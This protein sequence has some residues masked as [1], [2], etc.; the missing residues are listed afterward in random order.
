MTG[1]VKEEV[2]TRLIELGV[3]VSAGCIYFNPFILRQSEFLN[4]D[5]RLGYFNVQG[6]PCH[7]ALSVG[8]LGF[9]YCQVPIIYHIADTTAITITFADGR[10]TQIDGDAIDATTSQSIF[11]KKGQAVKINV[12]LKPPLN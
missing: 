12:G 9:T 11:D 4:Q 6:E 3:S 7:E 10:T 5:D 2:I 1:Q 8:Q